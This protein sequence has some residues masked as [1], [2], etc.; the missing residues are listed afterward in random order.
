LAG[1]ARET[2][3]GAR[4]IG[5]P[6]RRRCIQVTVKLRPRQQPAGQSAEAALQQ[7]AAQ[8]PADRA[9][10]TREAYA[11]AHGADPADMLA[12]ARFAAHHH[13]RVVARHKAARTVILSGTI[14][15]FERAFRVRLFR[16]RQG[17]RI[18]RGRTGAIHLPPRL[19]GLVDGVFGLDNRPAA[20]PH[21]RRRQGLGGAWAQAQSSA[22][23]P[24][25]V[26]QAYTFP[27]DANGSGQCIAIIELGG[28]YSMRD[29]NPYFATLG[30]PTPRVKWVSI[31]GAR[32]VPFGDPNGADGEVLLD[33]E[34]AGAVAP[35]ANI[36][37]YFAK[38][39]DQDFL[40]AINRAVHDRVNRPTVISISWGGPESA[41]TQQSLNA[42][43][44][45]FNAA[46]LLG[47]TVCVASGD[48]GSSD[49]QPGRTAHADFPA[50]SPNVVACGGTKLIASGSTISSEVVWNEGP[51][52]GAGGGGVSDFFALPS[53]QSSAGVPPS[54]NPGAHVGRGLPD[55]A[56]NA[57][58]NTGYEVRVDGQNG[59]IGGTSAVAPLM[60]GLTALLNQKLGKPIG[61]LNPLLY[62]STAVHDTFHDI[63]QGNNDMTGQVGHYP[64]ARG[65]DPAS[66]FGSPN[67]T[68]LLT[69]LQG[70]PQP[71]QTAHHTP[72]GATST[73]PAPS[74]TSLASDT[75]SST[76]HD[77]PSSGASGASRRTRPA[78]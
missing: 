54:P 48:G 59:V 25:Q 7:L 61:Y 64:A 32:N 62:Q 77:E 16:Y 49:G 35:G 40:R 58:P 15:A 18:Y 65:W 60:A 72:S 3:P 66:G 41:W 51:G 42:F 21:F 46:G 57:D 39:T 78:E 27:A 20:K 45:A 28:G 67:G 34:V 63:T 14:G 24:P 56:G 43:N 5:R 4:I 31:G 68:A 36:V 1:S 30:I 76:P 38:N 6:N 29:L 55:V 11:A 23:T 8:S 50:S 26:A 75:A 47:V 70:S 69:Q 71:H 17:R 12:V 53:W 44:D 52:G 10:L 2:L 74:S 33:I 73:P 37:V 13:L 19:D 22:F 9:Y